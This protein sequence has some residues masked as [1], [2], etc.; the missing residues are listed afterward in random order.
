MTRENFPRA[1][2]LDGIFAA[3]AN[4]YRLA[5]IRALWE[6]PTSPVAFSD[7]RAEIGMRDPGQFYYHLEKLVP[8]LIAKRDDGYEL[9]YAGEQVVGAAIAGAYSAADLPIDPVDVGACPKC[10]DRIVLAYDGGYTTIGCAAC[11]LLL[12]KEMA[13]P[14]IVPA[15]A[16]SDD[17]LTRRINRYYIRFATQYKD[18]FC[19][20]CWGHLDLTVDLEDPTFAEEAMSEHICVQSTCQ[21]CESTSRHFVGWTVIDHPAVVGFFYDRGIDL[22]T[23]PAWELYALWLGEPHARIM[24]EDPLV[25][26][27]TVSLDGDALRLGLDE[28]FEVAEHHV[29]SGADEEPTGA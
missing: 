12:T 9:T 24:N 29:E 1:A 20:I 21:T 14:P 8:H 27:A 23:I 16:A 18:R 26:E 19:P 13:V 15:D 11:D 4:E 10:G 22:R 2:D 5:I 25:I 28:D 7:I 17:E 6:A 3:L